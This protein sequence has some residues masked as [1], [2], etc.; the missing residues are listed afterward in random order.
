MTARIKRVWPVDQ[1]QSM[2][3]LLIPLIQPCSEAWSRRV[4]CRWRAVVHGRSD[5]RL[6]D[7]EVISST[8]QPVTH[9]YRSD[10]MQLSPVKSS[11]VISVNSW[12]PTFPPSLPPSPPLPLSFPLPSFSSFLLLPFLLHIPFLPSLPFP[13]N[14]AMVLGS[15]V[16][17]KLTCKN[18]VKRITL[19]NLNSWGPHTPIHPLND[20]PG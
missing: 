10:V 18:N 2:D 3:G 1:F 6:R 8:R 14:T 5:R 9:V 16:S 4:E 20:A 19:K 7:H 12:G 13:C 17:C 11:G 15:A